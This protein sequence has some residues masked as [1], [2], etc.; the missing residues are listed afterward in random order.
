MLLAIFYIIYEEKRCKMYFFWA[1][2]LKF[3]SAADVKDCMLKVHTLKYAE[4]ACYNGTLTIKA[5]SSGVEFGGCNWILSGPKGDVGYISC[6][7]FNS[8]H[9]MNFDFRS[10]QGTGTLIYSDFSSLSI[11]RNI[12]DGHSSSKPFVSNSLFVRYKF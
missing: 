4:E 2:I 8:A 11:T 7:S 5:L 3:L 12:V 6:S 1:L 9:A 10:L